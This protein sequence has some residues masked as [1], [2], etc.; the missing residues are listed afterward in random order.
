MAC[1]SLSGLH[2]SR[3]HSHFFS[4]RMGRRFLGP[5][6]QDLPRWHCLALLWNTPDGSRS[7]GSCFAELRTL[8]RTEP[9]WNFVVGISNNWWNIMESLKMRRITICD[10]CKGVLNSS[11]PALMTNHGMGCVPASWSI[12]LKGGNLRSTNTPFISELTESTKRRMLTTKFNHHSKRRQKR[13]SLL[14]LHGCSSSMKTC[15]GLRTRWFFW[16]KEG[17]L[18]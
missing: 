9:W 13:F 10:L 3:I 17:P 2:S 8:G 18:W 1:A 15:W 5:L 7:Q 6:S 11:S 4:T 16:G 12:G 14:L